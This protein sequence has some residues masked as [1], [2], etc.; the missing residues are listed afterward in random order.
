MEAKSSQLRVL[1]IRGGTTEW[2]GLGWPPEPM[3][4]RQDSPVQKGRGA[5]LGQL[6]LPVR[7]VSP[8]A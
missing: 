7:A 8:G 3:P 1:P 2:E 4:P 6:E 5:S